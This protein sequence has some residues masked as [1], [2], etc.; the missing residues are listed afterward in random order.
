MGLPEGAK[1]I[2]LQWTPRCVIVADQDV[3]VPPWTEVLYL[4][5]P[6]WWTHSGECV[7]G[8]SLKSVCY[9]ARMCHVE[10]EKRQRT[11]GALVTFPGS[12]GWLG[13]GGT[14]RSWNDL[15][16]HDNINFSIII[17]S[18]MD[19]SIFELLK[20]LNIFKSV[21]WARRTSESKFVTNVKKGVVTFI[22]I[23]RTKFANALYIMC[24][25]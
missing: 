13:T 24:S 16:C 21:V 11:A 5:I 19:R 18:G 6:C 3:C 20:T 14:L 4:S 22:H 8:R 17:L 23:H 25:I 15:R 12:Q 9:R 7:P 2:L 10:S 1:I